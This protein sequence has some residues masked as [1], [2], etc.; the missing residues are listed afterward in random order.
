VLRLISRVLFWL[1]IG[2]VFPS[3]LPVSMRKMGQYYLLGIFPGTRYVGINPTVGKWLNDN[4]IPYRAT[5]RSNIVFSS[6][7]DRSSFEEMREAY[8]RQ[9][10]ASTSVRAT[11]ESFLEEN[12][13]SHEWEW[14]RNTLRLFTDRDAV[15]LAL[16]FNVRSRAEIEVE[17]EHRIVARI[18]SISASVGIPHTARTLHYFESMFP[19]RFVITEA[20][21]I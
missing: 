9:Y 10:T 18:R 17:Q 21:S 14:N 15:H 19:N 13:I 4:N 20:D 7:R 11:L 6:S 3:G 12:G 8:A 16:V 2:P 5:E 1:R